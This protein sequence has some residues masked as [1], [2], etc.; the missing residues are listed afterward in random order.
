MF[1]ETLDGD[2][3]PVKRIQRIREARSEGRLLRWTVELTGDEEA[4]IGLSTK[5]DLDNVPIASFAAAPGTSVLRV[6]AGQI[7]SYPVI[8]WVVPRSG[9]P[10][11]VTPDGIND[12]GEGDEYLPTLFP[13]GI[14]YRPEDAP[15]TIEEFKRLHNVFEAVITLDPETVPGL[16]EELEAAQEA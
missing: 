8:G 6:D 10:L 7:Y 11:P 9:N 5:T 1:F 4:L 16:A 3:I 2:L 13:D 15:H 12:G 14:V